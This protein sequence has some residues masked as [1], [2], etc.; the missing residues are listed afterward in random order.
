MCSLSLSLSLCLSL[1]RSSLIH[2]LTRSHTHSLTNPLF[3]FSVPGSLSSS[4]SLVILRRDS[5]CIVGDGAARSPCRRIRIPTRPRA[6]LG[7]SPQRAGA[8]REDGAAAPSPSP[9]SRER[10][11]RAHGTDGRG[12]HPNARGRRR[13]RRRR[14]TGQT[15][16]QQEAPAEE[17]DA[18]A[19]E[20]V[21][22][23]RVQPEEE[24][25]VH[26]VRGGISLCR[27]GRSR[28][29]RLTPVHRASSPNARR[30][31]ERMLGQARCSVCKESFE[32]KVTKLDEAIDVYSA[33]V[34][35]CEDVNP[36]QDII[37]RASGLV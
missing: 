13:R 1:A 32:C 31:M 5:R 19:R 4:A 27:R 36:D 21:R 35:A 12:A 7:A 22:V 6:S 29:A 23:P 14:P 34:D 18:E 16:K 10:R 17:E 25:E 2:S 37:T 3:S 8:R 24:R 15:E 20:S 11:G 9:P 28:R 26:D 33:W 30:D